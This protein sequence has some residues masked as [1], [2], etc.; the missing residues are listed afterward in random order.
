MFQ[1]WRRRKYENSH[2][3]VLPQRSTRRRLSQGGYEGC[4]LDKM[5]NR[6]LDWFSVLMEEAGAVAPPEEGFPEECKPEVRWMFAHLDTDGD[7]VL[8]A[9]NLYSLS[10]C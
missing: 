9:A 10:E 5:A 4:A 2:N 7:G 8:S 6:L 1:V 3:D